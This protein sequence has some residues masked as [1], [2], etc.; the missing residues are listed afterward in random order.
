MKIFYLYYLYNTFN[1][2]NIKHHLYNNLAN[3]LININQSKKLKS[4]KPNFFSFLTFWSK[5]HVYADC[6][7]FNQF[8][9]I[10]RLKNDTIFKSN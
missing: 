8:F 3:L 7:P 6:S 4:I 10:L 2:Q 5:S 9:Y 1:I